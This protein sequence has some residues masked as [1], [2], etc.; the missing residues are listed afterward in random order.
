MKWKLGYIGAIL[1]LYRV[2]EKKMESTIIPKASLS[3]RSQN[4]ETRYMSY[5]LNSLKGVCIGD[6]LWE[7]Y[8]GY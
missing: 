5:S 8:R 4:P 2:M 3:S 6:Y 7:Y 1:G